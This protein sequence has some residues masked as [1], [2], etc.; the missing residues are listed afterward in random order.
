MPAK[1]KSFFLPC[2]LLFSLSAILI[3]SSSKTQA[4]TSDPAGWWP[5]DNS[6]TDQSGNGNDGTA[7]NVTATE[8]HDGTAN[9][10]YTFNGTNSKITFGEPTSLNM[11]SPNAFT[12]SAW[13][14]PDGATVNPG[15][16]FSRGGVSSSAGQTT[17]YLA[18]TAGAWTARVSDGIT[19]LTISSNSLSPN[20][21]QH[22]ALVWNG[23]TKTLNL[24]KNGALIKSGT[25]GVFTT[26][27]DGNDAGDKSTGIGA[28]STG[29]RYF[30]PGKIDNVR[31][32][33]RALSASDVSSLYQ[34]GGTP[35]SCTPDWQCS[36]W[37]VCSDGNQTRTCAD[38]NDCGT[39]EGKPSESQSCDTPPP[40]PTPPNVTFFDIPATAVSLT[41]SITT[42][43]A[44][45]NIAVTGYKLTESATQPTA[46]ASGWTASAPTS[47][48][49]AS[50][51]TKTLYAWA[52]DAAGNVS[53]GVS[54]TVTVT[55]DAPPPIV[56]DIYISQSG[57]G[58]GSSCASARSA[59]WFNTSANWGNATDKIG[60]G[61]T[62]T[63]C[64]SISTG[65]NTRAGGTAGNPITI[66]GQG[67]ATLSGQFNISHPYIILKESIFSGVNA[68]D[69]GTIEIGIGAHYCQILN[70]N[71]HDVVA[72]GIQFLDGGNMPEHSASNCIIKENYFKNLGINV[73]MMVYGSNHLIENNTIDN[74][75][76]HDAMQVFGANLIIRGNR[77]KNITDVGATHVDIIQTYGDRDH[78]TYNLLFEGN[79]IEGGTNSQ[80]GNFSADHL[81]KIE[82]FTFRNNIYKNMELQA[83]IYVPGVSFYNNTFYNCLRVNGWVLQFKARDDNQGN[84]I[85]GSNG[86]VGNNLF[87][88]C[89]FAS[90]NGWY[91]QYAGVTGL[92]AD[93]N[94]VAGDTSNLASFGTKR[95]FSEAH[96][97]NGGDP[98]FINSAGGDLHLQDVSP[99]RG[100]GVNLSDVWPNA[101]DKDGNPRPATGPWDIGAYEYA[102]GTTPPPPPTCTSFTYSNWSTCQANNTQSRTVASSYPS[103][104]TGGN[105][106]LSQSCIYVPPTCTSFT[107]SS[108]S[109][110]QPDNTQSRTV[111]SSSPSGCTGGS[112]I[113]S[114]SCTYIPPVNPCTSFTY[115]S[116]STCQANNTQSR[117]ILTSSP[118]NC[119][120]GSPILSQSCTYVP[121]T[122]TSFT[123]S[124]WSSCQPNN[125]Q[126]RII[127]IYSPSG[128]IGGSPILSQSCTYVPSVNNGGGGG[129][130][131]SNPGDNSN[132]TTYSLS[133][134]SSNGSVS[135][136]PDQTAYAPGTKV[137]LMAA[138]ASGYAF[139]Y[140]SSA[141]LSIGSANPISITIDSNKTI[142]ANFRN[143]SQAAQS[144][145]SPNGI[146]SKALKIGDYSNDAKT[147][148]QFLNNNGF[149]VSAA[150]AGSPGK[151]SIYFGKLTS[152]ALI[153]FQQQYLQQIGINSS[154]G[155]LD[156]KTRLFINSLATP[157]SFSS[158]PASG[159]PANFKFNV[160]LRYGQTSPDVKYLQIILN[161]DPDTKV[162]SSGAGS[163]GKESS[164]FGRLTYNAAVKFQ[165]KYA[166][167]ISQ[168]KQLTSS[169]GLVGPAT[170]AQLNALLGR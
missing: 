123:Y 97:I 68:K 151:E 158:A 118:L 24:F 59:S 37:S 134:V 154:S 71:V 129:E 131:I 29:S 44:T 1:L 96:G 132:S 112:P 83:N 67:S 51:G 54:D 23:T 153:K 122:C 80:I 56:G 114:Q 159:I 55:L 10:A 113:L 82:N 92:Q 63:L 89:G 3:V 93:Y 108:W 116:W 50:D 16:I 17:Y 119:T 69:N 72:R 77:Y 149:T 6:A 40:D 117:T 146:L 91:F 53:P 36:S 47:Y 39:T 155:A 150:G 33:N 25:D 99:A 160:N 52:K 107:Y 101:L 27:W 21:W 109:S 120:G 7:S 2:V 169:A 34:E 66:T 35:P 30:F 100:R 166:N 98:K 103:G 20:E 167:H 145:I 104:C 76:G 45:D 28:E 31:I 163:P 42:F 78:D 9:G 165:R 81:R 157:A 88:N 137:S 5:M 139:S 79:L 94:Y 49:F 156:E 152:A 168:G 140:W 143:A 14:Y 13:V 110:C 58:D 136:Y 4:V 60:P 121:P 95:F 162:A 62:V 41:V 161:S 75:G 43:T 48:T 144:L 74:T 26:L 8:G 12:V 85:S 102:D 111:A 142:V 124:D 73:G 86:F 61:D 125:T 15:T 106:I 130:G 135:K 115:S 32:Y 46:G 127:A 38:N 126:S 64:G 11:S 128:C 70:N 19:R 22:L 57:T 164:Y 147:L 18:Q 133:V 90:N 141:G 138:P 87:I 84:P 105:P 148:Q 170:R 65:L